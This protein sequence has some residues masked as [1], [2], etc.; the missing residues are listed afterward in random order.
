MVATLP[1]SNTVKDKRKRKR[2]I[3][4]FTLQFSLNIKSNISKSFLK[5][6]DKHFPKGIR[7]HKVFNRNTVK[8]SYS[9]LPNISRII[10]AHNKNIIKKEE[11]KNIKSCNCHVKD[12]CPLNGDRIAK[13]IVYL[14]N[15]KSETNEEGAN[16]IGLTEHTFKD[17]YY[18]HRNSF[19]YY[20]N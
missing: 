10:T 11:N 13:S 9:C 3:I 4:W 16:N 14:Y 18:K 17:R 8:V 15:V 5:L 6:I 19:Q 7:L 12:F 2:K 1:G 20:L